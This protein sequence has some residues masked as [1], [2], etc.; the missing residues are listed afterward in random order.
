MPFGGVVPRGTEVTVL[1]EAARSSLLTPLDD[2]MGFMDRVRS[3]HRRHVCPQ[4]R[5][6]GGDHPGAPVP[7][8]P[9]QLP[10]VARTIH[11]LAGDY[12][13]AYTTHGFYRLMR[14]SKYQDD[15]EEAVYELARRI[16]DVPKALRKSPG[17]PRPHSRLRLARERLRIGRPDDAGRPAASRRPPASAPGRAAV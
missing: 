8:R 16:R 1:S 13:G 12:G 17:S 14:P 10:E 4:G 5:K 7:V 6:C 15:Y 11:Y 2:T 9:E 3:P